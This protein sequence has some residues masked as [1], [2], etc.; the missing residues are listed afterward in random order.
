MFRSHPLRTRAKRTI[1][2]LRTRALVGLSLCLTLASGAV[3]AQPAC[4]LDRPVVFAGQ[5]WESNLVLMEI[6][7]FI[8][9]KGYG[10]RTDAL[11]VEAIIAM[12]ALESG[13]LDVIPEVW[14]SSLKEA[15]HRALASGKV[16][17]FEDI[18]TGRES[19]F[20]P[21]YTA[22]KL[23]Q[24]MRVTDLPEYRDVFRDPEDPGKGRIYGCP[25]G[26]FCEITNDN[27]FKALGL[28]DSFNLFSPG[29]GPT[30]KAAITAAYQRRE[31]MVFYYWEPTALIG[32]LDLV[33][34]EF[35]PYDPVAFQCLINPDCVDPR[36][37]AFSPTPVF[38]AVS[39]RFAQD[40]PALAAF[41]AKVRLPVAVMNQALAYMEQTQAEP[42]AVARWFLQGETDLWTSWI[43]ADVVKRVKAAL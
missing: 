21:R 29:S 31:D 1:L 8:M 12:A 19:W 27:L 9:E 7:R 14:T 4:E 36:P 17:R 41:L 26:W 13:D 38:T 20:I 35:P 5:N 16:Q 40:A 23:P 37:S 24:L 3:R 30:Q 22:E 11:S 39:S 42:D 28:Q 2:R 33:A 10:C 32:T 43:P 6:E 18:F 15:W 34:L 25:A